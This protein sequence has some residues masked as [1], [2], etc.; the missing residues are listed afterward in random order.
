MFLTASIANLSMQIFH[1]GF[2]VGVVAVL[3]FAGGIQIL[4]P[5]KIALFI[6]LVPVIGTLSCYPYPR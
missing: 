5:T 6:T 4:G 3:F 2:L 1:Q